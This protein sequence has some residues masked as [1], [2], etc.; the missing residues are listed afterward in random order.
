MHY[1]IENKNKLKNLLL[2]NLNS[3]FLNITRILQQRYKN[4]KLKKV[5]FLCILISLQSDSP[6]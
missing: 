6:F 1:R 4:Q 3:S 2:V 5:K